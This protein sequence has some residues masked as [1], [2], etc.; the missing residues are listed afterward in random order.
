L[1]LRLD[2]WFQWVESRKDLRP[3]A[4]KIRTIDKEVANWVL[5]QQE[6]ENRQWHICEDISAFRGNRFHESWKDTPDNFLHSLN[7]FRTEA[8]WL[9]E[10]LYVGRTKLGI[11]R[12]GIWK[13]RTLEECYTYL[14]EYHY[15]RDEE[16]EI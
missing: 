11:H 9:Y 10:N 2:A 1:C 5:R 8:S 12:S 16:E 3:I 4:G 6:S 7:T 13:Q 15:G 14:E